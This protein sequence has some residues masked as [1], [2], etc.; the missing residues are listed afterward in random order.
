M[1]SDTST[2]AAHTA[3][4]VFVLDIYSRGAL[5]SHTLRGAPLGYSQVGTHFRCAFLMKRPFWAILVQ[6]GL[7]FRR[8]Y[9]RGIVTIVKEVKR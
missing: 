1:L 8:G 5:K 2:R 9:H 3:C 4:C 7:A 6:H